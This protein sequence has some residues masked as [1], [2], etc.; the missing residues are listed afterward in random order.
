[1]IKINPSNKIIFCSKNMIKK[2]KCNTE[3]QNLTNLNKLNQLNKLVT[4]GAIEYILRNKK[5]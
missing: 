3:K 4:N 1:M 5:V 2:N